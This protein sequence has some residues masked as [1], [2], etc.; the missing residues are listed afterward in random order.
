MSERFQQKEVLQLKKN[1]AE[2][3]WKKAN[4]I[5]GTESQKFVVNRVKQ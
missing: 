1:L 2:A 3:K 5:K 4:A